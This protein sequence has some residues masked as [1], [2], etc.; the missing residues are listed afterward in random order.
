VQIVGGHRQDLAVLQMAYAFE[1][2]TQFG[3]QRPAIC[4][5]A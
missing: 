4:T 1:Q 2:V 5:V 3:L